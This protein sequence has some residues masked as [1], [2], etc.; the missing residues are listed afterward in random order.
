M[1]THWQKPSMQV[2]TIAGGLV[3]TL[4]TSATLFI[5][6]FFGSTLPKMQERIQSNDVRL[7]SQSDQM[8]RIE[9]KVEK[10]HDKLDNIYKIMIQRT[11]IPP[12]HSHEANK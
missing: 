5:I 11:D 12:R 4:V 1:E 7:K 2:K 9:E 3:T 6:S 10:T 8:V